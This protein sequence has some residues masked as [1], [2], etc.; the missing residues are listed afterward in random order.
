VTTLKLIDGVVLKVADD[1]AAIRELV[2]RALA[3]GAL[4]E[5]HTTEGRSITINAHHVVYVDEGI[6]QRPAE[7][8]PGNH[9]GAQAVVPA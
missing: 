5:I 9:E 8:Q 7:R 6:R 3:D 2:H 1:Y 4:F